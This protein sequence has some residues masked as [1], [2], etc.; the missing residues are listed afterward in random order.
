MI[1]P[2]L[3]GLRGFL[4]VMVRL[5]VAPVLQVKFYSSRIVVSMVETK[6]PLQGLLNV[7]NEISTKL[8]EIYIY[9]LLGNNKSNIFL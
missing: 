5:T 4:S 2:E 3:D 1:P 7:K 6:L 8:S 9:S